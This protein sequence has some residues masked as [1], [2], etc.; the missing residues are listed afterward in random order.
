MMFDYEAWKIVLDVFLQAV[1]DETRNLLGFILVPTFGQNIKSENNM[2]KTEIERDR[3]GGS[4]YPFLSKLDQ[5]G[6][7]G[8][9]HIAKGMK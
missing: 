4:G 7:I 8:D 5:E 1:E 9:K 2:D 6:A 3:R